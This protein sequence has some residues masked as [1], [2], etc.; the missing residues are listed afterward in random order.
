[1]EISQH[2]SP[3]DAGETTRPVRAPLP[4]SIGAAVGSGGLLILIPPSASQS[5]LSLRSELSPNT[6]NRSNR[7]AGFFRS[8]VGRN[9]VAGGA[10]RV[11]KAGLPVGFG[12][13]ARAKTIA[14]ADGAPSVRTLAAR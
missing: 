5:P 2:W 7:S 14:D 12:E 13:T 8:G 3:Q 6:E 4:I 9:K 1:M 10:T 11:T